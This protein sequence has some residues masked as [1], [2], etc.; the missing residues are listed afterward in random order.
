MGVDVEAR[1]SSRDS[2]DQLCKTLQQL[3]A[4]IKLVP[5][6]PDEPLVMTILVPR[7]WIICGTIVRS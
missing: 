1:Q 3:T 6:W 7:S 4:D 5:G 2:A